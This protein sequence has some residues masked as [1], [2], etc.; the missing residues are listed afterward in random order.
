MFTRFSLSKKFYCKFLHEKLP[1]LYSAAVLPSRL[2]HFVAYIHSLNILCWINQNRKARSKPLALPAGQP[3]LVERKSKGSWTRVSA[4][5]PTCNKI[6]K[7]FCF[8]IYFALATPLCFL[9]SF[10][11]SSRTFMLPQA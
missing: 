11:L 3:K 1:A 6:R 5:Q 10:A 2:L 8:F 9:A 7:S 4:I